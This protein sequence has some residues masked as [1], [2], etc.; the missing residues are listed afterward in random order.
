M[1][2]HHP[3]NRPAHQQVAYKF[4][5]Y[6]RQHLQITFTSMEPLFPFIPRPNQSP[7]QRILCVSLSSSL[8]ERTPQQLLTLLYSPDR[9]IS[10]ME[11]GTQYAV[12]GNLK[13][14]NDNTNYALTFESHHIFS[15]PNLN[16]NNHP[17]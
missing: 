9:G 16:H 13:I 2:R 4:T 14:F 1:H 17:N 6:R 7:L 15:S 3:T 12:T 8:F 11:P 5:L 10:A